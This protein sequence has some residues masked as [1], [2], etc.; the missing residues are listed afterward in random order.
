MWAKWIV[1]EEALTLDLKYR[2]S[3][4]QL[5]AE[6]KVVVDQLTY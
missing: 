2:V 3:K 4:K 1:E 5:E 6:N